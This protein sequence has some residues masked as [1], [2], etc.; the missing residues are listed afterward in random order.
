MLVDTDIEICCNGTETINRFGNDQSC[1]VIG[2]STISVENQ[3]TY[4]AVFAD[5]RM[6]DFRVGSNCCSMAQQNVLNQMTF[7]EINIAA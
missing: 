7:P 1:T 5:D 3:L 2:L 4:G 6:G